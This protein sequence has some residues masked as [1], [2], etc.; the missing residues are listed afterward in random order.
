MMDDGTTAAGRTVLLLDETT[1]SESGE[2]CDELMH[3]CEAARR[4]ELTVTF[5]QDV[6]DSVDFASLSGGRQ[7][8]KRGVII[9]GETIRAVG[10]GEPDFDEPLVEDTVA[11][12]GDLQSLGQKISRFCKVWTNAGYEISVCFDSLSDLLAAN[13]PEVVFKFCHVLAGR[14]NSVGAVAH[15]HLDPTEH[16]QQ[17]QLTFEQIFDETLLEEIDV[18]HL[19]PTRRSTASDTDVAQ[20]TASL[21]LEDTDDGGTASPDSG[22]SAGESSPETGADTVDPAG[23]DPARETGGE[24]SD[25]EIAKRFSAMN[26]P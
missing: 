11:D 23:D 15:F 19:V 20:G 10:A 18:E 12:P 2:H 8:A 16:S 4:A 9:V 21:T 25:E 13:D 26:G 7:P 3:V 6:T 24:A 14:L 5:P 1:A 17:L 22:N